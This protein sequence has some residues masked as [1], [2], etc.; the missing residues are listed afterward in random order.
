MATVRITETELARDL[1][2]VLAKVRQGLEVVIEQDRRPV[3]VLKHSESARP[4][5]KLSE[6]IALAKAYEEKLRV[7]PLPD[8]H[9]AGD[10]RAAIDARR[11]PFEPPRWE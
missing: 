11:D 6:C 4:G 2:A 5:R 3:A 1:H 7:A 10:V 9:F 8:E